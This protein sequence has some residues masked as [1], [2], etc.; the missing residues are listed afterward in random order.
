M[1]KRHIY[2]I[3]SILSAWPFASALELGSWLGAS[4]TAFVE[5]IN[6]GAKMRATFCDV[7]VTQGLQNV[8]NNCK[9]FAGGG[10]T[11]ANL[12]SWELLARED[13]YDFILVDAYHDI[14]SVSR[15]VAELIKRKPL[16]IMAHDTNATAAGYPKAEGAKF[17]ADVFRAH[18]EYHGMEDCVYREG[19]RT[20]RGLF[21][22]T[23]E[24]AL[25]KVAAEVF[26][27]YASDGPD[28]E[29]VK[30]DLDHANTFVQ[31]SI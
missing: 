16:C 14:D 4:A 5:A 24:P 17:L 27:F 8:V 31:A 18:P 12:P 7:Q 3:F 20:E 15:E 29:P 6:G 19:E 11:I 2:T 1:D 26:R 10:W 21:F 25:F 9:N 13:Q 23:T 30:M 22:A 28:S